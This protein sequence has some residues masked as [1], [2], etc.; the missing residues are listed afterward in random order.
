MAANRRPNLFVVGS[1]KSGTNT[2][3][4]YLAAHP[5]I[6]MTP[7]PWKEPQFFVK[8]LNW[9]KGEEWYL[10]LFSGA[11]SEPI[12]GE[13]STFYSRLP[14][15]QGVAERIAAFDAAPR[16]LYIMR[17]PAE[18]AVSHY[19]WDVHWSAEGRN[20]LTAMKRMSC[21]TDVSYYAMQLRPYL[22][23]FGRDRVLAFTL[24]E[25]SSTPA[26]TLRRIFAWLQVDADFAPPRLDRRDNQ[27]PETVNRV[28][29][30]GIWS[31][32]RGGL[33]WRSLKR[34]VPRSVRNRVYGA[35]SRPIERD[36]TWVAPTIDYLRPI[37]QEQTEELSRLLGRSFPE[38][39]T[40]Y[41]TTDSSESTARQA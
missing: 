33:L 14:D 16:I 38:W 19:W 29:G 23:L 6:Y 18:R 7:R 1:M 15:Y 3:Y 12:V 32:L 9:S 5:E 22:H 2:L 36:P 17:D 28:V 13:A 40:L 41:G 24:E 39:T 34:A 4:N 27:S 31:H 37:Q 20:M 11:D 35:L 10:S 25:L 26:E 21:Y 30:S 8:E